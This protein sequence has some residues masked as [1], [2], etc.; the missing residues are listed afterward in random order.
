MIK[1]KYNRFGLLRF[2]LL[3]TTLCK[4]RKKVEYGKIIFN[5]YVP[6]TYNFIGTL[7]FEDAV[8][9]YARYCPKNSSI[10]SQPS[11]QMHT[12]G[13]KHVH[14]ENINGKLGKYKIATKKSLRITNQA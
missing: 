8:K 12:V 6:E 13:R 1:Q 11:E 14:L 9:A 7:I 2:A 5:I 4:C 10:F 3:Q